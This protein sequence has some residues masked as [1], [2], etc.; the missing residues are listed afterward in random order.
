MIPNVEYISDERFKLNGKEYY[1][2]LEKNDMRSLDDILIHL[3]YPQKDIVISRL[4]REDEFKEHVFTREYRHLQNLKITRIN[5]LISTSHL[6]EITNN[7]INDS[8]T[9]LK[10]YQIEAVKFINDPKQN[11]LL[12]VHG[13]GTGKTLTALAASQGYIKMFPNDKVIVISPASLIGNFE[14]EMVK[15]G[16]E[17]SNNYKFYSFTKFMNMNK[18]RLTA[19]DVFHEENVERYITLYPNKSEEDISEIMKRVFN[20]IKNTSEYKLKADQLNIKASECKDSMI[21]IDECHNLRNMGKTYKALFDYV[22]SCK[23]LLLLT[24]TPFVN[25]LYDF[26]SLI[27]MLHRNS[28]ITKRKI[29]QEVKEDAYKKT[30]TFIQDC[31]RGKITYLGDKNVDFPVVNYHKKEIAMTSEFLKKYEK[32]LVQDMIFG[33]S[34][35]VFYNGFRRAVNLIGASEYINQKLNVIS[36]IVN[37]GNQTL[38]FTNWLES[39][40]QVLESLFDKSNISYSVISGIVPPNERLE[41]VE[42]FNNKKIQVLIITLAGSE[43]LDLKE[44]NDVIILDPVWNPSIM[45]QIIGRAVRYKS[46]SKLPIEKR[47]VNVHNLIIKT[48]KDCKIP[49]GDE[50]LYSFIYKKQKMLKDSNEIMAQVSI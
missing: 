18:N 7:C 50:I 33:T 30:L 41:I 16:G 22:V 15:Y 14:K 35:E 8:K 3:G 44:T 43:G 26:V 17:I 48:S 40:V 31:L 21:I 34:P 29:S 4:Y 36:E 45:E 25:R 38:I 12:V 13:T 20:S 2:E 10:D 32:A 23:K 9:P 28:D 49:S 42:D 24:A 47:V 19:Y 1:A 37:K 5:D 6:R 39:G 11:S 27:N 46:H